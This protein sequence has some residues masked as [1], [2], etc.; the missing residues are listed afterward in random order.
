[1]SPHPAAH[2]GDPR[3]VDD[4]LGGPAVGEATVLVVDDQPMN[5][6]LLERMLR[7]AGVADV[8]ALTDPRQAVTVY[9]QVQPD[10]VVLDLHMPQMDGFTVMAELAAMVPEDA[11]VPI[12]VLTAD[13][14]ADVRERA[15]SVGAHDFLT[16]PFDRTE[17]L[18]R[19][20][21]LLETRWLHVRLRDQNAALEAQV[22]AQVEREARQAD[23]RRQRVS[24][25]EQVLAGGVLAMRF[26]PIAD[27]RTGAVLGAEALARFETEPRRP[28]DVWFAEALDVG[29]GLELELAAVAAALPALDALPPGSYLSVNVSPATVP[30][31]GLVDLVSG[32]GDRVVLE[33]TEH[34]PVDDY[35]VVAEGLGGL[36]RLGARLAVDDAGAGFASLRHILRLEPDIIKL[37]LALT[38]GID[39]DPVR[40]ALASALVR[41]A[42]EIGAVI[43]A[44]GVESAGEVRVL[45]DLGVAAGQGYYLA[46]P[47]PLPF[48]GDRLDHLVDA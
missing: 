6:H 34:A 18:L 11:F 10:L 24:R 36:R 1:M 21:N 29:L 20:K 35:G 47:G 44:E 38:R 23:D 16:K 22:R 19:V 33:L 32:A 45:R 13:V 2:R 25:V 4:L 40:R 5:V 31:P 43:T 48:P 14:A 26:Q 46:R 30:E 41:F 15:L 28:P 7:S 3:P 17:F 37:D 42:A 8:A 27:L 9:E 12:L 39:G